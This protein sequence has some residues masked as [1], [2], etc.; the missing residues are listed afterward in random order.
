VFCVSY[1]IPFLL[2]FLNLGYQDSPTFR[3][4]WPLTIVRY[5]VGNHNVT[6]S[7]LVVT[8]MFFCCWC[9]MSGNTSFTQVL[10]GFQMFV[11]ESNSWNSWE[12]TSLFLPHNFR[13]ALVVRQTVRMFLIFLVSHSES[14]SGL[15]FECDLCGWRQLLLPIIESSL[16]PLS[17]PPLGLSLGWTFFGYLMP[18]F[19]CGLT[20]KARLSCTLKHIVGWRTSWITF[21]GGSWLEGIWS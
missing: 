20:P 1:G 19:Q 14:H 5:V 3:A 7:L 11:S 12:E 10:S 4:D 15:Q 2:C 18:C 16:P 8:F 17:L 21:K 6:I 9:P 13:R